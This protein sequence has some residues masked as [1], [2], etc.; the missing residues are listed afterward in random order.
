MAG[1]ELVKAGIYA[2]FAVGAFAVMVA[3][4]GLGLHQPHEEA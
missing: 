4:H 2:V 3:A 1:V